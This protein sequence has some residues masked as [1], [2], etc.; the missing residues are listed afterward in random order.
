VGVLM[1]FVAG[2]IVGGRSGR[3]GFEEVVSAVK[4]V[5][6][7]QEFEDLVKALRSHAGHVLQEFGKHLSTDVQEPMSMGS[8]LSQAK[9]YVRDA[10]ASAF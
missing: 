7:S 6:N 10:T 3:E 2:Y 9:E 1:A 8:I 4:D 5:K